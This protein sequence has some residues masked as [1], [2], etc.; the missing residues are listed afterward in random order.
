MIKNLQKSC[1]CLVH[2]MMLGNSEER[3]GNLTVT[4]MSGI[5]QSY[6]FDFIFRNT[7]IIP[8]TTDQDRCLPLDLQKHTK[9]MTCCKLQFARLSTLMPYGLSTIQMWLSFYQATNTHIHKHTERHRK[10][11]SLSFPTAKVLKRW[12][13]HSYN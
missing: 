12:W 13:K 11:A 5:S 2:K 4:L 1:S 3:T 9:S 7:C 6:P 8:M 10:D